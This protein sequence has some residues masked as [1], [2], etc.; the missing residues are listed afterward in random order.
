[1]TPQRPNEHLP[2]A[3]PD[4]ERDRY[5]SRALA[6]IILNGAAALILVTALA[7]APQS[8]SDPRRLTWAMLVFGSGALAGLLSSLLAYIGRTAMASS[9]LIVQDVLRVGAII[10]AVGSGAAFLTGLNIMALMVPE[11]SST[12]PKSKPQDQTP[13]PRQLRPTLYLKPLAPPVRA[14]ADTT[15]RGRS[16]RGRPRC[17]RAAFGEQVRRRSGYWPQAGGRRR[18]RSG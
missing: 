14:L 8:A 2:H 3:F 1:M 12:R 10:A 6:V 15:F 5:A 11:A 18:D 17:R 9:N 7:F 13:Q 16:A 4:R